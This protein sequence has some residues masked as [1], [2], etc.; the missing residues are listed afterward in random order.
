MAGRRT[1][2]ARLCNGQLTGPSTDRLQPGEKVGTHDRTVPRSTRLPPK[3]SSEERKKKERQGYNNQ[4]AGCC[5][6]WGNGVADLLSVVGK[7]GRREYSLLRLYISRSMGKVV[8]RAMGK[9]SLFRRNQELAS[10]SPLAKDLACRGAHEPWWM[11]RA[12]KAPIPFTGL[13]VTLDEPG[14][15]PFEGTHGGGGGGGGNEKKLAKL[16]GWRDQLCPMSRWMNEWMNG[17]ERPSSLQLY[18]HKT[19]ILH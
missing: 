19:I 15:P 4:A 6:C 16:L 13:L 1:T 18:V 14:F 7:A 17:R 2:T 3:L 12:T 9:L 5:C 10:I 8:S 11:W